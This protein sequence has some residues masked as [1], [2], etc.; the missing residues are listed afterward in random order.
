MASD[1]SHGRSAESTLDDDAL[2][3][4]IG[5]KPSFKREFTNLSTVR[6]RAALRR[7]ALTPRTDQLRVQHHGPLLER[8]DDVQHAAA[9][10]RPGVRDVV[11][12]PRQRHV[13][14]ARCAPAPHRLVL[15]AE[16]VRAGA[17]VAEIVSAFPTCGGMWVSSVL[18]A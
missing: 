3:R 12:A 4:E 11:L 14:H 6:P 1:A 8:R 18:L 9:L 13:P 10:R 2:L 7:P 16:P 15:A 5:Y 17:S